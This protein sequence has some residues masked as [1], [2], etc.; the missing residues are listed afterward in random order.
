MLHTCGGGPVK[1][2]WVDVEVGDGEGGPP[3]L[4]RWNKFLCKRL[5]PM[6]NRKVP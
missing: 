4:R 2:V 6:K 1:E 3:S 5:D